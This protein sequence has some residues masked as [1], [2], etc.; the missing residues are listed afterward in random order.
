MRCSDQVRVEGRTLVE[1]GVDLV[2]V[3]GLFLIEQLDHPVHDGAVLAEDGESARVLR[4]DDGLD[5]GVYLR[6]HLVAV[7]ELSLIIASEEDLFG[8]AEVHIADGVGHT[9]LGDHLACDLARAL[10]VVARARGDV[11]DDDL[12]RRSA[13]Q[14]H[15]DLVEQFLFGVMVV[16]VLRQRD[17][18]S[19]RLTAGDDADLVHGVAVLG[20]LGDDG[21]PGFVIGGDALVALGDDAALLR[22]ARDDLVDRLGD[23][24]HVDDLAVCARGEDG[25]LVEQVLDVRARETGGEAGKA[26]E[27]DVG[28]ERLVAAV[29]LED[30]LAPLDVG[31]V[32]VDLTVESARA[33]ERGVEDVGAVGRRHHDYAVVGLKAVHLDEEL[34]QG[35]LALVVAAAETRA[36]L[37]AHGVYLVDEDDAGHA[38]FCL[39]E[40]VAHSGRAHAH[41]HLHEVGTADGEEG[42]VRLAR[43]GFGKEGLA[44]PGRADEQHALG[45]ARAD[46]G[47]LL[48]VF[49]K[50][51]DLL[52]LLLFL[53]RT[54]HVGEA[55]LAVLDLVGFGFAE[56][57]RLVVRAVGLAH[58]DEEDHR[59]QHDHDD[60]H[61]QG[62]EQRGTGRIVEVVLDN[63]GGLPLR[64][65]IDDADDLRHV[66][67]AVV[68]VIFE[69]VLAHE[70][71]IDAVRPVE[72]DLVDLPALQRFDEVAVND[73]IRPRKADRK[74]DGEQYEDDH[75]DNDDRTSC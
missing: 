14:H 25:C 17:G 8:G 38:V 63:D 39:I 12:F 10:D 28:C 67:R 71:E 6:R 18:I 30:V 72:I 54:R 35:L 52:Q 9:P 15:T 26:L 58:D 43:N 50:I 59:K 42:D 13:A 3:D 34:V 20:E 37:S 1:E 27:I 5:L 57:K 60:G 62:G 11:F 61:E 46:G 56:V 24:L 70:T 44:R 55:H 19:R 45:D 53:F 65:R 41:E 51:H 21:V 48:W 49:Q 73:V 64:K 74:D 33:H 40:E 69:P 23:V 68:G 31:D 22:R 4:V 2:F 29:H 66:R 16:V 36:S 75:R 32:D 7:I 47:E